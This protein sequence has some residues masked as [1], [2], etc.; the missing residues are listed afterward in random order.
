[1]WG[2]HH[3]CGNRVQALHDA[4]Y[5]KALHAKSRGPKVS[6]VLTITKPPPA[7]RDRMRATQR[8]RV[9]A[10]AAAAVAAPVAKRAKVDGGASEAVTTFPE[11][12]KMEY[13]V[14]PGTGA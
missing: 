3:D 9:A 12:G 2:L 7:E 4:A 5:S 10:A 11:G 1:M 6:R 8:Q 14:L 13:I